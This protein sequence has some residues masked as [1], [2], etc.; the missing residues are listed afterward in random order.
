[1]KGTWRREKKAEVK[2]M[3]SERERTKGRYSGAARN[4]REPRFFS[5]LPSAAMLVPLMKSGTRCAA[6]ES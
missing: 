5:E 4:S 6:G 3:R 1:M 2:A